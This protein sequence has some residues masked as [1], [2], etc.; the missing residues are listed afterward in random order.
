MSALIAEFV[1]ESLENL[2]R[3][4]QDFVALEKRPGDREILARIFRAVHTL[5]GSCGFLGFSRLEALAH[6]AESLLGMLRDGTRPLTPAIT[7][8][9]LQT[10]D[11]IRAS[12]AAITSTGQE[13]ELSHAA[14]IARLDA[15]RDGREVSAVPIAAAVAREPVPEPPPVPPQ[16]AAP[17]PAEALRRALMELD[18]ALTGTDL[19]PA[20]LPAIA[21]A[22][23]E[24]A[25]AA[26]GHEALVE[27]AARA[28]TLARGADTPGLREG[29]VE[30]AAWADEALAVLDATGRAPQS[31]PPQLALLLDR[32]RDRDRDRDKDK[33][34]DKDRDKDRDRQP[35]AEDGAARRG[36]VSD[37]KI[38]VDVQLLDSLMNLVGELVLARNQI[39]QSLSSRDGRVSPRITQ[40]LSQITTDL[41][42]SVMRTRL[43]PME[44]IWN[45]FPRTV[46]DLAMELGKQVDLS[47]EGADTELDRS[48]LEAIRDPMTHLVRNAIDHGIEPPHERRAA[49]KKQAGGLSL[50]AWHEGGQV[51]IEIV[52]DGRGIDVA[53]IEKKALERGLI[54]AE[55][56]RAMSNQEKIALIFLPGLSTAEKVTT[57]SGRGVGM[58][59]VKNNIDQ[60]NGAIDIQ[61]EIGK[62]TAIRLKIPLT[63]AI[64]PALIVASAGERY[65]IPQVSLLAVI[66]LADE[67]S[68]RGIERVHDAAVFRWRGRLLPLVDLSQVLGFGPKKPSGEAVTVVVLQA[69][70]RLFGL[71][72]DS[73]VDSAE[74]VVKPV[75]RVIARTRVFTA[76][77]IMGDGRAAMILDVLG[78][79]QRA[80]VVTGRVEQSGR[81]QSQRGPK[82]QKGDKADKALVATAAEA[83]QV[84]IVRIGPD[85]A[86]VPLTSAIRLEHFPAKAVER[87]GRR[88]VAQYRGR[89]LPLWQLGGAELSGRD[90]DSVLN[91]VVYTEGSSSVG[92]V[93]DELVDIIQR[94]RDIQSS[95]DRT[96]GVSGSTIVLNKIAQVLDL[97]ALAREAQA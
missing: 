1:S 27:V 25:R 34:K 31:V 69:A 96:P 3:V 90:A 19:A 89:V 57:V 74:V 13:G 24:L 16:P 33:D 35:A 21:D 53:R 67:N 39:L 77:T 48:L 78:L 20:P 81:A 83:Q 75:N 62:G 88:K 26:A 14:V 4:D 11:G 79:A 91:V 97:P 42:A 2:E 82:G 15:L 8:A 40:R 43:Q 85:L 10:L 41:Q 63:L 28:A 44:I 94:P 76:A 61:T 22:F 23:T 73:V 51:N 46:R 5:K 18:R 60:V 52:D 30:T 50:R 71:L 87:L 9:L 68:E 7:T 65:V 47:M 84:L 64:V 17:D 32:E 58:D 12:L 59:V 66:S 86:V 37:S 29:L 45:R 49:G 55:Q 6:S 56:A 72:V 36:A 38:R 80:T 54:T 70:D 93:V 92:L 95:P